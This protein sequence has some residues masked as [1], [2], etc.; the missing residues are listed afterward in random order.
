MTLLRMNV[1]LEQK[2]RP[3]INVVKKIN[4]ILFVRYHEAGSSIAVINIRAEATAQYK[5][6]YDNI[7]LFYSKCMWYLT[8]RRKLSK[9]K[10]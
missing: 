2:I 5:I 8:V 10:E 7:R 9:S 6:R 4:W 1:L 3:T